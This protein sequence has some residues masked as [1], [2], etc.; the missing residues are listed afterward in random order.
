MNSFWRRI[1]RPLRLTVTWALVLY[2]LIVLIAWLA[3]ADLD[4]TGRKQSFGPADTTRNFW[5][6]APAA[7]RGVMPMVIY[8]TFILSIA[9]LQFVG[10]FWY[11]SRGRTYTM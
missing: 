6:V 8:A 1:R 2:I 4:G 11:M 10:I 3:G 5:K 7:I 9:I